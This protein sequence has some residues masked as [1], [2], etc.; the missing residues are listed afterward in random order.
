M[1]VCFE[2]ALGQ[3]L[4]ELVGDVED[5][6][7]PCVQ[8]ARPNTESESHDLASATEAAQ[9]PSA[10]GPT[11]ATG[12]TGAPGT[13]D[14]SGAKEQGVPEAKAPAGPTS[15]GAQPAAADLLVQ[16]HYPGGLRVR[17]GSAMAA[18]RYEY[19]DA[20]EGICLNV[21]VGGNSTECLSACILVG[22][23]HRQHLSLSAFSFSLRDC[24]RLCVPW[25][26]LFTSLILFLLTG[27]WAWDPWPLME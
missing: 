20:A 17:F 26:H 4:S 13:S 1:L 8:V 11:G 22:R 16:A 27:P 10:A 21:H 19:G 6:L 9:Y 23:G 12:P 25:P 24:F 18:Q 15:S 5:I 7:I 3:R 14:A 2:G